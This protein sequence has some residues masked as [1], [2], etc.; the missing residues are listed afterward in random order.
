MLQLPVIALEQRIKQELEVNPMLEE[1]AETGQETEL[2][3][4]QEQQ[5][6]IT[7]R[8]NETPPE[9]PAA[10]TE[11]TETPTGERRD[12]ITSGK[13]SCSDEYD[14]YKAPRSTI[15]TTRNRRNFPQRSEETLSDLL[16]Q[17]LRMQTMS[18]DDL[19]LAEEIIGNIDEHGYLRRDLR[20][21]IDDLNKFLSFTQKSADATMATPTISSATATSMPTRRLSPIPLSAASDCCRIWS[22]TAMSHIPARSGSAEEEEDV[23][24]DAFGV[25]FDDETYPPGP[26][27]DRRRRRHR[28]AEACKPFDRGDVAVVDRGFGEDTG[29]R[30]VRL[31][32]ERP[33]TVAVGEPDAVETL[34]ARSSR[35]FTESR[36]SACRRRSRSCSGSSGS[37]H[38]ASALAIFVSA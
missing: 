12:E 3:F 20:E 1:L 21:I 25:S 33:K 28:R 31:A 26:G 7:E 14:D 37:S 15:P 2:E 11:S 24:V 10:T 9:T 6:A 5:A 18:E 30:D 22:T 17:Q 23:A 4:E 35:S 29:A 38:L 13:S 32:T 27:R 8:R 34:Q 19:A 16:L 36:C